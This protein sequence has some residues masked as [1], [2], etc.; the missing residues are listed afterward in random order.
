MSENFIQR[1]LR[2][3][4]EEEPPVGSGKRRSETVQRL[5]IGFTGIA[6]MVLVVGLV[7]VIRDRADQ[8]DS[9]TVPEAA[10]TVQPQPTQSPRADP[11][12]ESGVVPD[13]PSTPS[14]TAAP[15]PAIVAEP[16]INGEARQD[17][18]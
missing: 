17:G 12:A 2:K 11:L 4:A 3:P 16:A 15:D 18:T 6:A 9:A 13:V 14:P 5:Q 1:A 10:A 8:V 7:D